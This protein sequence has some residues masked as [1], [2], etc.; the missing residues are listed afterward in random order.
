[1]LRKRT[2]RLHCG[3]AAFL[4]VTATALPLHQQRHEDDD[5]KRDLD[6][7]RAGVVPQQQLLDHPEAH[8]AGKSQRQTLH[9]RDDCRRHRAK[10]QLRAERVAADVA[11]R[12][13]GEHCGERRERTGDGP[14]ER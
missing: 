2:Q 6:K 8:A 3:P 10:Q 14:G 11:L 1:M 7:T 12:R 5:E 9:A 13:R 4:L